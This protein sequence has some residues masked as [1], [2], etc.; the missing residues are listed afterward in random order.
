[1]IP[2]STATQA[3]IEAMFSEKERDRVAR[4]LIEQCGDSLPLT[5]RASDDFWDRIRFA[6]LKLADGD[7]K[8]LVREIEGANRDWRD[9]L[10]AAGFGDDV[11]AHRLWNPKSTMITTGRVTERA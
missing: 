4:L 1:M 11:M 9:T 3:R 5:S 10:V 2:L 7:L 6:V 8:R